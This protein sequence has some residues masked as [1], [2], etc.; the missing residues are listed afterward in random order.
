MGLI[1]DEDSS[2]DFL[3]VHFD[4]F[5]YEVHTKTNEL[6]I[7][8]TFDNQFSQNWTY[9]NT[10]YGEG[11][12]F[13][14]TERTSDSDNKVDFTVYNNRS[15]LLGFFIEEITIAAY[16]TKT[17]N[18][19]VSNTLGSVYTVGE[20][21]SWQVEFTVDIPFHYNCWIQVDKPN[22][23]S[24]NEIYYET[25]DK[26]GLCSGIE[27][28]SVNL[29]IPNNVLEEGDWRINAI[30][31]NYM[32]NFT[33]EYWNQSTFNDTSQLTFENLFRFK[34]TLNNSISLPNTQINCSIYYP[35][36]SLF[37]N[38]SRDP[39]S[40]DEKF[41]NFTVGTNMTIGKY[42]A[43]IIWVNNQ[44]HLERDKVGF[45][46]LEFDIWHYTNLTAVDS[47]FE[48]IAGDPLALKDQLCRF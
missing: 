16:A 47:Y 27:Y 36:A 37:W 39:T 15:G 19:T 23:W 21:I 32:N 48:L 40:Y 10:S 29:I 5:K 17:F 12:S 4:N 24:F 41:G 7:V 44:S 3:K 13:I 18:S 34:A 20:N 35:N 42:T 45:L 2:S 6:G 33:L 1:L 38:L 9:Y 11:Y 14:D 31:S 8:K 28:G 22:D 25:I 43:E 26:T 46:K 30:S